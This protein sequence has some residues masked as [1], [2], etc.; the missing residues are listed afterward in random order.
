M[1]AKL[2]TDFA[3]RKA[4]V[5][6]NP[7]INVRMDAEWQERLASLLR[8]DEGAATFIKDVL[9]PVLDG[10]VTLARNDAGKVIAIEGRDAKGKR[11]T[12]RCDAA[13]LVDGRQPLA[14]APQRGRPK[15]PAG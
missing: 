5:G 15:K 13:P 7:Q 11:V 1:V 2:I 3:A 9:R 4:A 14:D 12:I 10:V 8:E 6:G